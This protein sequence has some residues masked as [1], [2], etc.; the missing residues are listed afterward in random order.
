MASSLFG[1][2]SAR[3][4]HLAKV[5]QS[6]LA[7]EVAD[8]RQD[9][10]DAFQAF[11]DDPQLG[12]YLRTVRTVTPTGTSADAAN[13]TAAGTAMAAV[14]GKIIAKA[15]THSITSDVTIPSN[16]V[17]EFMPGA[18]LDIA[19][20]KTVTLNGPVDGV[21]GL[22]GAGTFTP[23]P[24]AIYVNASTGSDGG[25]GTSGA[26]YKT[27][28]KLASLLR[29]L[30]P[31]TAV[32]VYATGV[33]AEPLRVTWAGTTYVHC[34]TTTGR[35]GQ[36]SG[37]TARVQST[38]TPQQ[39]TDSSLPASWAA[40]AS[41]S[42]W[43]CLIRRLSG[44]GGAATG[45]A[46]GLYEAVAKTLRTGVWSD[47][48]DTITNL[49]PSNATP[50][51]NDYYRIDT[52]ST[53]IEDCLVEV[54]GATVIIDRC[55]FTGT[56]G[57]ISLS[58][59]SGSYIKPRLCQFRANVYTTMAGEIDL[60]QTNMARNV[61]LVGGDMGTSVGCTFGSPSADCS[62][63]IH[64][65]ASINLAG[66]CT[67]ERTCLRLL[68]C[69]VNIGSHDF[70]DV[71]VGSP[72]IELINP[73]TQCRM[74]TIS[75][76]VLGDGLVISDAGC[77][78]AYGSGAYI[79]VG[80]GRAKY[81]VCG[82]TLVDADLIY[83]DATHHSG[84][85]TTPGIVTAMRQTMCLQ[86][87]QKDAVA[88]PTTTSAAS[89]AAADT[90]LSQ[91]IT[92][93]RGNYLKVSASGCADQSLANAYMGFAITLDTGGGDTDI[94]GASGRT[95]HCVLFSNQSGAAANI[96]FAMGPFLIPITA[97]AKTVKLKWWAPGGGQG[98][99]Q[100]SRD[101]YATIVIEEWLL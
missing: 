83:W 14:G 97:G 21:P 84:I 79:S 72:A 17:V 98:R 15:G 10:E 4:P 30:R 80:G 32:H 65:G 76:S 37:A 6:G 88:G 35:T 52:L 27:L 57:L 63:A 73:G 87:V 71:P 69:S 46:W 11:D 92:T 26:P 29:G 3:R 61:T 48:D 47:F 16:V 75:G 5:G 22:T 67:W 70:Y 68:G 90:L 20:T 51:M 24:L 54:E 58:V 56:G 7:G 74:Q 34:T 44:S 100:E 49:S 89:L 39:V 25:L 38:N 101:E 59:P 12:L 77:V 66:D 36:L 60:W 45:A 85:V 64:D 78:I 93:T 55:A 41:M 50:A 9:V 1:S 62:A 28:G 94:T 23:Y 53:T 31:S 18:V 2:R 42:T 13:W 86:M 99:V 19:S 91:A 43:P 40:S 33:F 8:L 81:K 95:H 82:V 96:P